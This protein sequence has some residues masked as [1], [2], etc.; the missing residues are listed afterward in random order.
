[1]PLQV[2]TI[3]RLTLLQLFTL[4]AKL[5]LLAPN[6]VQGGVGHHTEAV[7]GRVGHFYFKASPVLLKLNT[8]TTDLYCSR[9][10]SND[11]STSS[12]LFYQHISDHAL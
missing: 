7:G 2:L 1:M 10:P 12:L 6:R 5:V 11:P 8:Y 9:S 3:L 4:R